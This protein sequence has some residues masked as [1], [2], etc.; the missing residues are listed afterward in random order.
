[1]AVRIFQSIRKYRRDHRLEVVRGILA[2]RPGESICGTGI[3][4][5]MAAVRLYDPDLCGWLYGT[6]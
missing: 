1:M 6:E 3:G 5:G 4:I 2:V